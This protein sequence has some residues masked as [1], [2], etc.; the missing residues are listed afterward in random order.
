M[1]EDP[2]LIPIQETHS[3]SSCGCGAVEAERMC[4]DVRPIP[5][6]LRHPAV[7]GAVSSLGVGEGFDLLAPHVPTPLLA[8]IDQLPMAVKHTLL[9]AENGFARVEIVRVG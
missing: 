8:Q 6:R 4:L 9:E 5:H 7:L 3:H 2:K 1:S